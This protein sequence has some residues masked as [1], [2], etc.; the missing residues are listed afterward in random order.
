[1]DPI[2]LQSSLIARE[3][4][5]LWVIAKSF[6]I[7]IV[8]DWP[9]ICWI[10]TGLWRITGPQS[11]Q[12]SK[13]SPRNPLIRSQSKSWDYVKAGRLRGFW[14]WEISNFLQFYTKYEISSKVISSCKIPLNHTIHVHVYNNAT[15]PA[16]KSPLLVQFVTCPN[17]PPSCAPCPQQAASNKQ[18]AACNKQQAASNKQLVVKLFVGIIAN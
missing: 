14:G 10:A 4:F 11:A 6:A 18:K 8:I 7:M 12:Q 3:P 15:I 16:R 17:P 9:R 5:G 2:R 1:M 13:K